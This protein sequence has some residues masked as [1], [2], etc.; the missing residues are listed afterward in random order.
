MFF[1]ATLKKI[2]SAN[3]RGMAIPLATL[4]AAAIGCSAKT[5]PQ[6]TPTPTPTARTTTT[7]YPLR[8]ELPPARDQSY[9]GSEACRECHTKISEQYDNHPMGQ[10]MSRVSDMALI[11][12]ESPDWL[13]I[14]GPNKYRVTLK[15]PTP[16]TPSQPSNPTQLVHQQRY[17]DQQGNSIGDIIEPIAFAMGSGQKG[18]AYFIL[19]DHMLF[20]SPIGW[21]TAKNCWDLSPGYSPEAHPGFQRRIDNSC[22]YCHAGRVDTKNDLQYTQQVFHEAII[23]CERCHGPGEKHIQFHH[24]QKTNDLAGNTN[25]AQLDPICNPA[26]LSPNAREDVCNQCHLQAEQVIP[27]F[28]RKFYDFRPGDRLDDVFVVFAGNSRPDSRTQDVRHNVRAVSHV[29]QMRES[30]CYQAAPQKMGCTSCH[31]PHSVPNE[32]ERIQLYRTSCLKCHTDQSCA[33]AAQDRRQK[34][35]EDSCIDCHMPRADLSNVPHTIQTDHRILRNPKKET[36]NNKSIKAWTV[37]DGAQERLPDWEIS[38][39]RGLTMMTNALKKR[40]PAMAIKAREYL[41]PKDPN[42]P[43]DDNA[44]E[45]NQA[46]EALANDP[47]SLSAIASSYWLEGLYAVAR[48]FWEKTLELDPYHETALS[49]LIQMD[50]DAN[51]LQSSERYALQLTKTAPAEATHWVQLATIYWKMKRYSDAIK[52]GETAVKLAPHLDE[53]Q[54]W[55]KQAKQSQSDSPAEPSN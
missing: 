4:L 42:L 29:E 6:S 35:S 14:P 1:I 27:R 49:G 51:D 20:Q 5:S 8:A 46:L 11:E 34:S 28:G 55:L 50:L 39:A 38:R 31:D 22:L 15:K 48:P 43:P 52:A 45:P 9:V 33:L 7:T 41:M 18:R 37:V 47:E 13:N 40:D 23:G 12:S 53:T 3:R 36:Q 21:Y 32:S 10:S 25:Q 26:D 44:L 30:R 17:L 54:K 16:S 2:D 19:K 24:N